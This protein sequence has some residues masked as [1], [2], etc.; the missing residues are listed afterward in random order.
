[1]IHLV[2]LHVANLLATW[3]SF[4]IEQNKT[5]HWISSRKW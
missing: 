2:L 1:M 3:C 4:E 5:K